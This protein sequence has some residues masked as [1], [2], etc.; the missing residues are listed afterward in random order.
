MWQ[1]SLSLQKI[2]K[3]TQPYCLA[4]LTSNTVERRLDPHRLIGQQL[5]I[6]CCRSLLGANNNSDSP[7]SLDQLCFTG[8]QFDCGRA[9]CR[10]LNN[11]IDWIYFDCQEGF[12]FAIASCKHSP[13]LSS[14]GIIGESSVVET[15]VG[16]AR[17]CKIEGGAQ[18]KMFRYVHHSVHVGIHGPCVYRPFLFRYTNC[19]FIFLFAI[20]KTIT[21]KLSSFS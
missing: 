17:V 7:S 10:N 20:R 16:T 8:W 9:Q 6:K 19:Q 21:N 11:C 1:A 18:F 3:H 13:K 4:P 2:L 14:Q 15:R 12:W 5:V